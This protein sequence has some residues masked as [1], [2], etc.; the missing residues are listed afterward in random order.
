MIGFSIA[1]GVFLVLAILLL[2]FR[3][4]TLVNVMK[5]SDEKIGSGFNKT[6][7]MIGMVFMVLSFILLFWYSI[8]NFHIY[9]LPIASEHGVLTDRMFW[10]TT[11]ITG[12]VF[13]IT[14]FLLFY[15]AYKYQH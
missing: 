7:A 13:I 14:Q 6:N 10:I 8:K 2:I 12:V 1:I 3:L 15:F 5:Q 9:Q 11:A 4:H